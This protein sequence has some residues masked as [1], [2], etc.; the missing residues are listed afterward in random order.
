[1]VKKCLGMDHFK[2]FFTQCNC[3]IDFSRFDISNQG[4]PF[5]QKHDALFLSKTNLPFSVAAF[6]Q[7][8]PLPNHSF[9]VSFAFKAESVCTIPALRDFSGGS[10]EFK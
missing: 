4:K 9:N 7:S 1:M 6:V 5:Y 2:V 3:L 10:V 8:P